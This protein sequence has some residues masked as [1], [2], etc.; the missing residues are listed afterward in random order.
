M[1]Q[2]FLEMGVRRIYT[3]YPAHL[4][5]LKQMAEGQ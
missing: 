1:S 3:D 5:R 4:F 2:Q